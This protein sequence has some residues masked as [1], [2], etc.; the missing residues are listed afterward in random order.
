MSTYI[1]DTTFRTISEEESHEDTSFDTLRVTRRGGYNLLDTEKALWPKGKTASSLGYPYM[2]L[3]SK[4]V[5]SGGGSSF[6]I[7]D[8]HFE[9]FLTTDVGRGYIDNSDD[10]SL[11]AGSFPV[12]GDDETTVQASYF[13]QSNTTR[14]LSRTAAPPASPRFPI[15]LASSINVATLFDHYPARYPGTVL[16]KPVGRLTQFQRTEL[17]PSVWAV[18]ETW[19]NRVEADV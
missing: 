8:L 19:V 16:A 3:R 4:R 1:G 15:V 10:I 11:Q 2:V 6:G 14:W 9:G 5:S 17:A 7:I 13:A 18:V 12:S